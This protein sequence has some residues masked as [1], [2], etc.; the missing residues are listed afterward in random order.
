M[1]FV[2]ALVV[3]FLVTWWVNLWLYR[4]AR[5]RREQQHHHENLTRHW[6]H[7]HDRDENRE[8]R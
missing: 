6:L 8:R 5:R 2:L 4:L 1:T 7:T 3:T